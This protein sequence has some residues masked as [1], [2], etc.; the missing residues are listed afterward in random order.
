MRQL[1]HSGSTALLKTSA[2]YIN[3]TWQKHCLELFKAGINVVQKTTNYY[4]HKAS[5]QPFFILFLVSLLVRLSDSDSTYESNW[6][7]NSTHSLFMPCDVSADGILSSVHKNKKTPS[8]ES[9][10]NQRLH[11]RRIHY[12]IITK[13][14]LKDWL[15]IQRDGLCMQLY[16]CSIY[17]V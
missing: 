5:V 13:T 6:I 7:P 8:R 9:A 3:T 17:Y 4:R 14:C 10:N 1:S 16:F 15:H 11:C 2:E 12:L